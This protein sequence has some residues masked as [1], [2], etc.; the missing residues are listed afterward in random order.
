MFLTR[1]ILISL[2][3]IPLPA[4][5]GGQ[6]L[7]PNAFIKQSFSAPL[8]KAKAL[9]LTSPQ[10]ARI[11]KILAHDFKKLRLRYWQQD[12]K[13]AWILNE[14]GKDKPI[15]IGVVINQG[16]IQSIKVLTFRESRGSEIRH[17]FFTRQFEQAT[18]Q[19]TLKL[20]R[21]IDGISGATLSVRAMTKISRI[22][23]YLDQQISAP[24]KPGTQ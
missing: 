19:D 8:P 3:L 16:R 13:T 18:L 4:F 12:N 11:K 14:V 7:E 2:C 5:A 9:W 22:A 1:I 21:H 17:D 6:Y 20:D 24:Q 10:R 23:L 15:T